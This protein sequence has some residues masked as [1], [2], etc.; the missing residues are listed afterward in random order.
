MRARTMKNIWL[1]LES[2]HPLRWGIRYGNEWLIVKRVK[3]L[4]PM[5]SRRGP[6]APHAFLSTKGVVRFEGNTAIIE[7]SRGC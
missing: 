7:R 1:F 5:N 2:T 4:V 3:V 6:I